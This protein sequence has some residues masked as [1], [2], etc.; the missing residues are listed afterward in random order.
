IL[1]AG[2]RISRN[3]PPRQGSRRARAGVGADRLL[4]LPPGRGRSRPAGLDARDAGIALRQDGAGGRLG[5]AYE[6]RTPRREY[7]LRAPRPRPARL[8]GTAERR[9]FPAPQG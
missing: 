3:A 7:A 6:A 2:D 9:V 8:T 1:L 4:W 5:R